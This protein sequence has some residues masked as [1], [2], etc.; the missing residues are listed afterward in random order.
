ET[1][2]SGKIGL[3][4]KPVEHGSLYAAVGVVSLPPGSFLS[5]PDI[6]RTGDN[7]FP[8]FVP[9]AKPQKSMN[10]EVGTKWNFYEDRLGLSLAYFLTEKRDVP[11][12]GRD[13]DDIAA[14]LKGYGKQIVEGVEFS[15]N[16]RITEAWD[17]FAGF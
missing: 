9:G 3:V 13:A 11:I 5:N 12:T 4:Y 2:L 10:A 17:V 1:T 15:I 6:S 7:A 16:G 8:G 14:T